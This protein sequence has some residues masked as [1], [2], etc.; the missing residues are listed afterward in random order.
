M[1]DTD[2]D[3]NLDNQDA[4]NAAAE[5]A[6]KSAKDGDGS[7]DDDDDDDGP[8][9]KDR[10]QRKINRVNREA[11]GLRKRLLAAEEKAN[12]YDAEQASKLSKEEKLAADIEVARKDA[13]DARQELLVAR[14]E[15]KRPELTPA[16]IK[17]LVG[18]TVEELLE[19]AKELFGAPKKT[20]TVTPDP[21]DV[22]GRNTK[23]GDLDEMNPAKLAALVKRR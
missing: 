18:T 13:A 2:D 15:A 21:D 16:Q 3:Q 12:K 5:A 7:G 8:F 1:A 10:A 19:D 11:S 17:R 20:K 14:V 9:D 6:D 22:D 23:D 4:D